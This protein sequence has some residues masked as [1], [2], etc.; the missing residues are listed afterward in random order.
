LLQQNL[1]QYEAAF[2]EI[3]ME[4]HGPTGVLQ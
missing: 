1:K 2:G 4:A 3:H